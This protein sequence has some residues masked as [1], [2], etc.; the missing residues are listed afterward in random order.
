M[1]KTLTEQI[2][3]LIE[4]L[5]VKYIENFEVGKLQEEKFKIII[6]RNIIEI[7]KEIEILKT[8]KAESN[9]LSTK[10]AMDFLKVSKRTLWKYKDDKILSYS[11]IKGKIYFKLPDLNNFI[12]EHY[13][14]A[15]NKLKYKRRS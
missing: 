11:Q 14:P 15:E 7:K 3:D 6:L 10:E 8:Q 1:E 2:K 9:L 4:S 12:E 5:N 13:V